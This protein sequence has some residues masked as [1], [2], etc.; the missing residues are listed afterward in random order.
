M[1]DQTDMFGNP[2]GPSQL[3][4]FG[5]GE[6]RLQAPAPKVIDHAAQA[7]NRL[8]QILSVAS[9]ALSMPW[10]E[11]DCRMWQTVFPQMANWLPDEEAKQLVF[12]FNRQID[13]LKAA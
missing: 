8:T 7:R 4:L 13:R 1:S 5:E 10:S 3:N 11:R 6:N 12:E 2:A 9:S